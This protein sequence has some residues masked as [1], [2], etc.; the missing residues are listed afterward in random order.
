[1]G[2]RNLARFKQWT[3]SGVTAMLPGNV[4]GSLCL[5][6]WLLQAAPVRYLTAR[7]WSLSSSA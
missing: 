4:P 1:M 5:L 2:T 3:M 7:S 6:L